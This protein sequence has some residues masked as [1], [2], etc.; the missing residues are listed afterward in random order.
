VQESDV[1]ACRGW[2]LSGTVQGSARAAEQQFWNSSDSSAPFHVCRGFMIVLL[3]FRQC[4][5]RL[6][7]VVEF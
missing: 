4:Y 1:D 3:F 2:R 5:V 7:S 6:L